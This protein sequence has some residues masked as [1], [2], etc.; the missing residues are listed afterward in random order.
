MVLKDVRQVA[1]RE[2]D[3]AVVSPRCTTLTVLNE[4][5]GTPLKAGRPCSAQVRVENGDREGLAGAS[6][7]PPAEF[8][9]GHVYHLFVVRSVDRER[10]QR[11]LRSWGI[12]TLV[13]YPVPI[14][15]QPA[16]A[17]AGPV[18]CPIATRVCREVL[19]LPLYPGMADD[20]VRAVAAAIRAGA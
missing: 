20:D 17:S 1:L 12:E 5:A 19:S 6:V 8:D 13:H 3:L 9:A 2:T 7:T 15:Q 4:N 18:D 16:L 10:L 14:P 11:H